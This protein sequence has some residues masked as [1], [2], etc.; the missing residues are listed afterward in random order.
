MFLKTYL[1]VA[2]EIDIM[3]CMYIY[4]VENDNRLSQLPAIIMNQVFVEE[5]TTKTTT[6]TTVTLGITKSTSSSFVSPISTTST[7]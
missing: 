1:R 2:Y 3:T 5:Q 6:T 4:D 7:S